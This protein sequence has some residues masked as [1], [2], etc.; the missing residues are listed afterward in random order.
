MAT[1]GIDL[2][3]LA[4]DSLLRSREDFYFAPEAASAAKVVASLDPSS[5][6]TV[7]T[8]FTL[9]ATVSGLM[10]RKARRVTMTLTDASG[11]A[12]G[13]SVTVLIVGQRWGQDV[14]ELLT[15]T[16]T[17]GSAT[18][19]TSVNVYDQVLSVTPQILTSTG[20][21]DALTCGIDGTSFGLRFP[22]DNLADVQSL[23]NVSTNTE[24]APT[25]LSTTTV[26]AGAATGGSVA[27]GSY[28]KGITLATTD[29]WTVRY[30]TSRKNDVSGVNGVWR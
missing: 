21:G 30:L 29:R 26:Q 13:L 14:R 28:I 11:G 18:L 20:T 6:A 22:I 3:Q 4:Y 19:G 10:L 9:A 16:C 27:G 15:V 12:G 7:G 25:A 17:D 1:G 24:A 8:A 2:T 23:I 5:A